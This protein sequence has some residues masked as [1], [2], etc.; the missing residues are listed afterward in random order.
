[1]G[2]YMHARIRHSLSV[3]SYGIGAS[4]ENV[5]AVA[6]MGPHSASAHTRVWLVSWP[7]SEC[8]WFEL[9]EIKRKTKIDLLVGGQGGR[10]GGREGR[11]GGGER[12]SKVITYYM[13][14]LAWAIYYHKSPV[15][16]VLVNAVF[17]LIFFIVFRSSERGGLSDRAQAAYSF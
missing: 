5:R 16:D 11:V 2:I 10:E 14:I 6:L 3:L 9:F 1:V 7:S 8:V 15:L 17:L 13:I 12:E 4:R